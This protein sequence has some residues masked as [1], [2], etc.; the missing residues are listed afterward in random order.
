[1][2]ETRATSLSG[3]GRYPVLDCRTLAARGRDDVLH[4]IEATPS[5]IARGLGRSYGDAALNPAGT[6]AMARSDRL[7]AFDEDTGL[8][9]CEAGLSLAALLRLFVP[10]G[11]FP[12]VTP[13]T[14]H[15]TVGGM[16]AADVHGKNHHRAGSFGMHVERLTLATADGRVIACSPTENAGLFA[17]TIGGMGLTGIVLSAAFRLVPI[18]T[19]YLR[20]RT[21]AANDLAEAIALLEEKGSATYTVAWIDCLAGGSNIGR[22]IVFS[23]EHARVTDLPPRRQA[24]PFRFSSR[25]SLAVPL[26]APPWA[27]SPLTIRA[28]NEVYFR[29]NRS[30][31]ERLLDYDRFFYPLDALQGWNRLYGRR[32]FVQ[33]QCVLPKAAAAEGLGRL[34]S[35]I[36]GAGEGSFL[37]VLK[38][39]GRGGAFMSFPLE[40]YTLA[41]DLPASP[42]C[43]ALLDRLDAVVAD[44]GGRL[45]LAKD[46]RAS[47]GLIERCYPDI[48]R[49]RH[50]R[51][52]VDPRHKFRSALSERIGL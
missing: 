1:V 42:H 29:G 43:L 52:T 39:L 31:K 33:Y 41:L 14:K 4:A 37:A 18:E 51:A 9:E 16:I 8:L 6:L 26:D 44:C 45:Y 49:F 2:L 10:R 25:R 5:L 40:G 46:A 20:Q 47:A 35:L 23:G 21:D 38:L 17:A 34:L 27:L 7:I 32:G 12:P 48:D 15:V 30:K 28:F 19:A 24:D 3:W 13:G 36:R 22:S 50:V 11:W